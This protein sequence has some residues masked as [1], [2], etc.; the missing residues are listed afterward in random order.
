MASQKTSKHIHPTRRAFVKAMAVAPALPSLL[1]A[2]PA[3]VP[4]QPSS[5]IPLPVTAALAEL[6][7]LRYGSQLREGQLD[8]IKQG[9]DRSARTSERLRAFKLKN[10]DEPD[11]IFH[12]YTNKE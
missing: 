2:A 3:P 12:V 4:Q 10:S 1:I 7:R 11:F 6:V 8:E 9:L 5:P